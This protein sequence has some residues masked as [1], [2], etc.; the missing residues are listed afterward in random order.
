[1][2]IFKKISSVIQNTKFC[3]ANEKILFC[4][5]IRNK[6][7]LTKCQTMKFGVVRNWL[8]FK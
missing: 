5:V 4:F 2:E 3:D 8:I 7:K 1:M 6:N